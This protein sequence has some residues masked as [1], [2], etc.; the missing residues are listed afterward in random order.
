[1]KTFCVYI[2]KCFDNTYYTGVSNDLA[3]RISEHQE[4]VDPNS[5]TFRRRPLELVFVQ[6]FQDVKE[7]ISFEKRLKGWSKAKKEAIINGDWEGLKSL[8]ECKNSSS[9][10]NNSKRK[11]G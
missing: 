8:A 11:N 1:M 6:N 2:L 3:R 10:K 5:Y 4:G 9:H 7:A